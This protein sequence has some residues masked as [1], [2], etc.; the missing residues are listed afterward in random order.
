MT[1]KKVQSGQSKWYKTQLLLKNE[2][3]KSFIPD[4]RRMSR[5]NLEQMMHSYGMIYIKPERGT[6]GIGVIR[7]ERREQ[8]G[9]TYQYEETLRRFTTFEAFHHSL[10]KKL[11]KR[12]YL[13]QKGVHLLKHNGRRFDIRV[14]VQL[15]PKG[16]WEAT[17][18]IG[19]LGHPRKIVT[20]YHS[21]GKPTA[22]E[23]LLSTHLS[24]QQ[25]VQLKGD[26]NR[27]G[28]RIAVQLKKT[29]LH[30]RQFGVDIGLDRSLK[31]WIIEVNMNPDPYIF[32]Q[33]KDKSMYR[34]VMR[35]RRYGLKH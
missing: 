33:L 12:S 17:G 8:E 32:N 4:T 28:T 11:G 9:Y 7:A 1:A 35:Y 29:F 25:L 15:S 14:M 34:R 18:I 20:N 6:Y 27:L 13:L 19:R 2:W 22:V 16:V 5:R 24:A 23:H 26:M 30:H 31:P 3:I 10:V 21:G